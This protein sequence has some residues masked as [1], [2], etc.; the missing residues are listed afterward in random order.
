MLCDPSVGLNAA[1]FFGPDT[2]VLSTLDD[3]ELEGA[4][5][6]VTFHVTAYGNAVLQ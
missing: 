1:V 3:G 6:C 5:I 2:Q 4:L